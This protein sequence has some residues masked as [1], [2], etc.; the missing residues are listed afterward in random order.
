MTLAEYFKLPASPMPNSPVGRLMETT[1]KD[2]PG[3][4]FEDARRQAQECLDKAANRCVYRLYTPK[5]EAGRAIAR[6]KYF[7][8]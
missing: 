5:Q 1:L 3:I 7:A 4:E 2:S 6:K 8:R